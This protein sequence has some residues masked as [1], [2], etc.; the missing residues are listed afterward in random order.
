MSIY[1]NIGYTR[2]SKTPNHWRDDYRLTA[3]AKKQIQAVKAEHERLFRE[4]EALPYDMS[5]EDYR[6]AT[7]EL[8][9]KL[10]ELI[11]REDKIRL[12]NAK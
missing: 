6:K 12:I 2:R 9:I 7:K 1:G 8:N 5:D 10:D 3:K 11:E 4:F